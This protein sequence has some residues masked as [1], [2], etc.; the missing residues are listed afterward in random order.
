MWEEYNYK[1]LYEASKQGLEFSPESHELK[2]F[3]AKAA[4]FIS[5]TEVAEIVLEELRAASI[6]E[7]FLWSAECALASGNK[8]QAMSFYAQ[9]KKMDEEVQDEELD[10]FMEGALLADGIDEHDDFSDFEIELP[11]IKF[12]DV[13][14]MESVKKDIH[15]KMILHLD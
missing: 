13:G 15:L 2:L 14:G 1:E 8:S 5:K 10:K 6:P 9:A 12:S 11:K 3:M 7:A 4:Y